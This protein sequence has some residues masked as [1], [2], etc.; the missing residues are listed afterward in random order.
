[1]NKPDGS[2]VVF[3]KR[4]LTAPPVMHAPQGF[5]GAPEPP[6]RGQLRTQAVIVGVAGLLTFGAYAAAENGVF[7]SCDPNRVGPDGKPV[8]CRSGHGGG[9]GGHGFYSGSSARS[10]FSFGG[11]GHFGGLHFG[12]S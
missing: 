11:F 7:S 10:G 6:P 12:G 3:G 8:V 1:M 2:P 9:G 5:P 4:G